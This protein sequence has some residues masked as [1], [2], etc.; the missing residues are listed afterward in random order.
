[1]KKVFPNAFVEGIEG[2][3]LHPLIINAAKVA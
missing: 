2:V 1:M 3:G